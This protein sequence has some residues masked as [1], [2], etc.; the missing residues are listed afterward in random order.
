MKSLSIQLDAL[1]SDITD[2]LLLLRQ[3]RGYSYV[4]VN[5]A[6]SHAMT[7]LAV[8]ISSAKELVASASLIV[9]TRR[10]VLDDRTSNVLDF[11]DQRRNEISS[12]IPKP[13]SSSDMD[14]IG[15]DRPSD[16]IITGSTF[17]REHVNIQT[18][19]K[20]AMLA[21]RAQKYE[22]AIV[23]LQKFKSRS[24]A[25]YGQT[26]ENRDEMLAILVTTLCR[27]KEWDSAEEIVLMDFDG[28]EEAVKTLV[29][30]YCEDRRYNDAERILYETIEVES[31]ND[32]E[33]NEILAEIYIGK[34][35]YDR[36]IKSCDTIL[37]TVGDDHAQFYVSLS[38]LAQIYEA[39]GDSIEAKLHRDLLP[40]GIEGSPLIEH[41]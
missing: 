22:E 20:F 2:L 14:P 31:A 17:D 11:T 18:L 25:R 29:W 23:L 13:M 28:R 21:Y 37:K 32:T 4:P 34:G 6:N 10:M 5:D 8:C 30:C 41:N 35:D 15:S 16:S 19:L 33:T 9:N 27:L 3:P 26:F 40:P 38:I 12:W 39:K 24:E 7:N 1:T 36:A